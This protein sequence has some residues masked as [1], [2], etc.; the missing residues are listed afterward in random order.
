MTSRFPAPWRIV[1]IEDA[2][3]VQL[4]VLRS[5]RPEHSGTHR[6]SDD[7]RCAA[8]GNRFRKAAETAQWPRRGVTACLKPG[9][10]RVA[11]SPLDYEH[12]GLY[13]IGA[14]PIYGFLEG[15]STVGACEGRAGLGSWAGA[16][17]GGGSEFL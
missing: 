6:L 10:P 4:G 16:G 17:R 11:R 12:G 14:E 3:G 7:G 9:D 15:V 8:D 5:S 2:T 13:S 1:E